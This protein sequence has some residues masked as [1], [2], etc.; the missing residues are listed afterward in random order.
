M[1]ESLRRLS[2]LYE[3]CAGLSG[4]LDFDA[5]LSNL[6]DQLARTLVLDAVVIFDLEGLREDGSLGA[7]A[8]LGLGRRTR[9]RIALP[10]ATLERLRACDGLSE[11]LLPEETGDV[12][13]GIE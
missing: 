3:L 8:S 12:L 6:T 13:P 11:R 7:R 5:E 9:G 2:I 1:D 4:S 10:A